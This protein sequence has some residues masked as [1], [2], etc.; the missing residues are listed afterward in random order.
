[1]TVRGAERLRRTRFSEMIE[2]AKQDGLHQWNRE[3]IWTFQQ[4]PDVLAA[5]RYV[6]SEW[7]TCVDRED[8]DHDDYCRGCHPAL[9]LFDAAEDAS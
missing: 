8:D 5:V 6:L 3:F 4:H 1:V 7:D 9:W 2:Y